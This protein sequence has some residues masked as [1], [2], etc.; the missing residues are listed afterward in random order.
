MVSAREE[1]PSSRHEALDELDS[2]LERITAEP[3]RWPQHLA[4]TRRLILDR[5]PYLVIY[6]VGESSIRIVAIAHARRR[7]GYWRWRVASKP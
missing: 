4:G 2:A 6:Q 3:E 5:F 1:E 7:P